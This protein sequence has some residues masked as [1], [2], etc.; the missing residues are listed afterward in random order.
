M[1]PRRKTVPISARLLIL[2][3]SLATMA[4]VLW[5]SAGCESN[6]ESLHPNQTAVNDLNPNTVGVEIEELNLPVNSV[7][8]PARQ[9]RS[10]PCADNAAA[11]ADLV[12]SAEDGGIEMR[13]NSSITI[14][15]NTIVTIG[16]EIHPFGVLVVV[17]GSPMNEPLRYFPMGTFK[18]GRKTGLIWYG[19]Q[20]DPNGSP[21][22]CAE[23][24]A[25]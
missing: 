20:R 25:R 5:S 13:F 9:G 23:N 12:A 18:A 11:F 21:P 24:R 1:L 16:F 14:S 7:K 8:L 2:L 19:G 22:D 10:A 3:L 4:Y 17:E 6:D 15:S